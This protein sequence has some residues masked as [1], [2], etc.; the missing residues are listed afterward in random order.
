MI[1]QGVAWELKRKDNAP[2]SEELLFDRSHD[3]SSYERIRRQ[4][5]EAVV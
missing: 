1:I 5:R 4:V 2:E 3:V